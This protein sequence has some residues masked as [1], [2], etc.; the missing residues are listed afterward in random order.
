MKNVDVNIH[1]VTRVEGHGNILLNVRS[2]Q[3]EKL[4]WQIVEAP[5]FFEAMLRGRRHDEAAH[6]TCRICGMAIFP[7]SPR[8]NSHRNHPRPRSAL[9]P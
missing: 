9:S 1:H 3:I 7:G 4:E 5:R 2:G 8:C 6:V